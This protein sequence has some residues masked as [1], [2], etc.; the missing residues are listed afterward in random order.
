[1]QA[2]GS[3]AM[4]SHPTA[5]AST[6]TPQESE[7]QNAV[8]A[9]YG[10]QGASAEQ[11]RAANTYLQDFAQAPAAWNI[12]LALLEKLTGPGASS[13]QFFAANM[14]YTKVRREWAAMAADECARLS[15]TLLQLLRRAKSATQ[16]VFEEQ[17]QRRICLALAAASLHS[18][19]ACKAFI[20]EAISLAGNTAGVGGAAVAADAAPPTVV[21]VTVALEMLNALPEEKRNA[22]ISVERKREL[23]KQLCGCASHV[24]ALCDHVAPVLVEQQAQAPLMQLLQN[25]V[26]AC[27]I[28]L[29][30]LQSQ[31]GT[32]FQAVLLTFS[33]PPGGQSKFLQR[34]ASVLTAL[35][36][37][38]EQPRP[39]GRAVF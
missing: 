4:P 21:S 13:V 33:Q 15:T 11:Q 14:L 26:E 36:A 10:G 1:M 18:V 35:L 12:S 24:L 17:V 7:V 31:H 37:V 22:G 38:L 30:R 32:T 9:L 28:S 19:D 20:Q 29:T 8:L 27:Q 3:P 39:P 2:P 16:P 23:E 34:A 6:L 5:C 25:W